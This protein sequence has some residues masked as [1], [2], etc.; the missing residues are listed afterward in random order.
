MEVTRDSQGRFV[1]T[2]KTSPSNPPDLVSFRITNPIVY[3]KYWWKKIMANEG[4][5]F[6]LK[7]RPITALA[8]ATIAFSLAFGLGA[9]TTQN[10]APSSTPT[11]T[12][13]LW[14]ETA[15][16]GVLKQVGNQ[17]FLLTTGDEAVTLQTAS[18]AGSFIG[19]KVLVVGSYNQKQKTLIVSDI[20]NLE[21][22]PS[23][24]PTPTPTEIPT[25]EP[26][27]LPTESTSS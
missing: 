1:S 12:P 10:A 6:R 2:Q 23:P 27:P 4:I 7:V 3:I 5:E 19:R 15:L 8:I 11:P 25:P 22:L 20:Q 16:K 24:T 13:N 21:A 14:K 18:D 17:L 9:A 26:T